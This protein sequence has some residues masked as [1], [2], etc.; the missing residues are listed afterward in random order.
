MVAPAS[1]VPLPGGSPLPS[2]PT[3]ASVGL[4]SCSVGVLPSLNVG[5]CATAATPYASTIATT[6]RLQRIE[7]GPIIGHPPGL[8]GVIVRS[9]R[10][11]PKSGVLGR[12]RLYLALIISTPRL[13]H[14]LTAVPRPRERKAGQGDSTRRRFNLGVVPAPTAIGRELDP[15]D[16]PAPGPRQAFDRVI[17]AVGQ[18]LSAGRESDDRL[19]PLLQEVIACWS[20]HMTERRVVG[21]SGSRG[22]HE[23]VFFPVRHVRAVDHLNPPQPLDVILALKAWHQL[24]RTRFP[25]HTFVLC[26]LA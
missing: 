5:P 6:S 21:R 13:Q 3:A 15:A 9:S 20:I 24:Y 4:S 11:A 7:D 10:R 12:R 14:R 16:R 23:V 8:N 19:R 22:L 25:G 17:A 2:G 1:A 26:R 18:P